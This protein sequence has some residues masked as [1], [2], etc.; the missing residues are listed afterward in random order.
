MYLYKNKQHPV[1]I[2]K[3]ERQITLKADGIS[4]SIFNY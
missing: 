3:T 2:K 4:S 1:H